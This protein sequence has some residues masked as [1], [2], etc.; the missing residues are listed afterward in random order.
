MACEPHMRIV[1]PLNNRTSPDLIADSTFPAELVTSIRLDALDSVSPMI[2]DLFQRCNRINSLEINDFGLDVFFLNEILDLCPLHLR[3]LAIKSDGFVAVESMVD[4]LLGSKAVVHIQILCLE[5]GDTGLDDTQSL[6][7]SCFRSILSTCSSLS[8]LSLKNIKIMDVPQLLEETNEFHATTKSFP[9]IVTLSLLQCD[10][11]GIGRIRLLR[12][13]PNLKNLE[14]VV[15]DDAFKLDNIDDS[16][17]DGQNNGLIRN[18]AETGNQYQLCKS[19]KRFS[20]RCTNNRS[21][22]DQAHLCEFLRQLPSIETLEL[23]GFGLKMSYQQLLEISEDWTRQGRHLK[24]LFLDINPRKVT[25][26]GLKNILKY[27]CYSRLESLD[28]WCG[29]DLI[30]SFWNHDTQRSELPFLKSLRALHLR[31]IVC[32]EDLDKDALL[33]LNLT[34]KQMPRLVDLTIAA[35][36]DD[37]TVFQGLGRDPDVP[38]PQPDAPITNVDWS[39]ER[40]FLQTLTIGYSQKFYRDNMKKMSQQ[41]GKR[42]RFLE[43]FRLL[44]LQ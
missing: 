44:E 9:N 1:L 31:Q 21:H 10:V 7:W 42:F 43:D 4:A 27:Q 20:M 15:R 34:L 8:M 19:L 24:R 14:M 16:S 38:L 6:P 23:A 41:I 26:E 32:V 33:A 25:E 11:T 12:K 18:G 17:E 29:P 2:A 5:I 30:S 36:L 22:A 13:F 35:Q 37:F 39:Q 28:I 3:R 40:P